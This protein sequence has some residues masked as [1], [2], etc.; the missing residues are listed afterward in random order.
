MPN[1]LYM[2]SS[3]RLEELSGLLA[4]ALRG[5][6]GADPL[7]RDVIVVQT[8][9]VARWLSLRLADELGCCMNVSYLFPRNFVDAMCKGLL[10]GDSPAHPDTQ[11]MEWR[12]FSLLPELAARPGAEVLA[13]YLEDNR[14]IK[15][16]Q[17]S[18][19]LSDLFDQYLVHRPE[20]IAAWDAGQEPDD[21]QASLWRELSNAE[22]IPGLASVF[23]QL[24]ASEPA[25]GALPER[26]FLFGLSTLPELYVKF[27]QILGRHADVQLF[28]LAPSEE[29]WG[30]LPGKKTNVLAE[31]TGLDT[32]FGQPLLSSMGMQ[33][34][35]F[36]NMLLDA[37][38]N[39]DGD[40]FADPGV[41]TTLARLQTDLLH[42]N[43]IHNA[44]P[45]VAD[46]SIAVASSAGAMREVDALK[47][48]VLSLL[49]NDATLRPRDILVLAPDISKYAPCIE[50]AFGSRGVG[51]PELPYAVADRGVRESPMIDAFLCTLELAVSRKTVRDI[52]DYLEHPVVA[53]R[54]GFDDES[55]AAARRMCAATG[56]RW[57]LD[58][59]DREDLGFGPQSANSWKAGMDSLAL[60]VMMAG[61]EENVFA[62]VAPYAEAEGDGVETIAKLVAAFDAIRDVLRSLETARPLADW[63][64]ALEKCAAAILPDDSDYAG[65]FAAIM[66]AIASLRDCAAVAGPD[67]ADVR[68]IRAAL[69]ETLVGSIAPQ[70][71]LSGGITFAELKP[72]RSVP[73]R[74][75]CLL[76]MDDAAFPRQDKPLSFDRIRQ[77]PR[78]G[79]R[80]IRAGDRYL[81]LET[82]LCVRDHL[83]I[84]YAGVSPH[85]DEDTPPSVVVTELLEY[86]EPGAKVSS[87]VTRHPLQPFSPAYFGGNT[88]ALFSYSAAD[89]EAAKRILAPRGIPPFSAGP[90]AKVPEEF[91]TLDF[92]SLVEFL[93][94]PCEHFLKNVFG[95]SSPRDEKL[96]PE[97]E[98]REIDALA[99]YGENARYVG[100]FL[101]GEPVERSLARTKAS[102]ILPWGLA[103][104][105]EAGAI[106]S[107]ARVFSNA[108]KPYVTGEVASVGGDFAAG[109]G[110]RR[111]TLCARI[112]PIVNGRLV[113]YRC[114]R[115]KT[116]DRLRAWI[117]AVVVGAF[118]EDGNEAA[119]R[120]TGTT[121]ICRAERLDVA[122]PNDARRRLADLLSIYREGLT[123]PLPVFPESSYAAGVVSP[124]AR[125]TPYERA[126]DKWCKAAFMSDVPS[127]RDD[128]WN[129]I[130][131]RGRDPLATMPD[132][133]MDLANRIWSGYE[134]CAKE[135]GLS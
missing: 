97:E 11:R 33:G 34:R 68:T 43:P 26:V 22:A 88:G 74:V 101:E 119:A 3:N 27:L 86:L 114:A 44:A 52:L 13:R 113:A 54:F 64:D 116:K 135:T 45:K 9:G 10:G 67:A 109:E 53:G 133:F 84:S 76:G 39:A 48:H 98:P 18:R 60:G 121:A 49:D 8:P 19:K 118:A 134:T 92:D 111:V 94:H 96:P 130:V 20:L 90:M 106:A 15:R 89:C 59:R 112:G 117:A 69:E 124:K 79:D 102:G 21:W 5:G 65:E 2:H 23:P 81:F 41:A 95:L 38:F 91:L 122:I 87:L 24:E 85:G 35:D 1:G 31:E 58:G 25:L 30:D 47:N 82:L 105:A 56:V 78:R 132:E 46:G 115:M 14:A 83:Y 51:E 61:N 28:A 71:F 63:P 126:L 32:G 75:I 104:E 7:A 103:G 100:H 125:K 99:L 80:S 123:R 107:N 110:D 40:R 57:G 36:A 127:E 77:R 6:A 108:V 66:Q 17:L 55:L 93:L 50:A 4:E 37:D 72:M 29:F 131:W 12:I 16:Y 73:A 42:L 62:G 129:R 128:P 70:G 120:V